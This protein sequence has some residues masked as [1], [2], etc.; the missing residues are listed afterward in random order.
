MNVYVLSL[1]PDTERQ[2]SIKRQLDSAGIRFE[3]FWGVDGREGWH[4]LFERYD[5]EARMKIKGEPLLLGQLGCFASHYLLWERCVYNNE[6]CIIIE[7]DAVIDGDGFKEFLKVVDVIEERYECVRLFKSKSRIRKA[8]PVENVGGFRV[9]KFL[10]GHMSTTGYYLTPLAARKYMISAQKWVLPV[11]IYMDQFWNNKVECY[12]IEPPF[13]TNDED[14]T[15]IIRYV[16]KNRK[17]RRTLGVKL[18]R[19]FY[20]LKNNMKRAVWNVCY[21]LKTRKMFSRID[22]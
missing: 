22:L 19:E 14:F 21:M 9:C 18:R 12:G 8:V 1:L 7:D 2:E 13:L 15:S 16:P 20:L 3:F 5:E 6:S 11:D 10:K 4:E 17:A